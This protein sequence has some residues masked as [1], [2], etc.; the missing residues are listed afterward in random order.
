MLKSMMAL[1]CPQDTESW[2][3]EAEHTTSF[4]Y[5]GFL[6]YKIF[7]VDEKETLYF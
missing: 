4:S 7:R 2:R 6:E 3:S 5:G 1:Y